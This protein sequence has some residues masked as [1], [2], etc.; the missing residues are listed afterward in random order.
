VLLQASLA[1]LCPSDTVATAL[2]VILSSLVLL[3]FSI[4][5]VGRQPP[6]LWALGMVTCLAYGLTIAIAHNMPTLHAV[7][8]GP[9]VSI[10][11]S[12]LVSSG[13]AILTSILVMPTLASDGVRVHSAW[14]ILAAFCRCHKLLHH[15]ALAT[16]SRCSPTSHNVAA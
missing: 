8:A 3:L 4:N 6:V 2:E 14:T 10:L 16:C 11:L 12:T 5:R 15:D 13:A 1:K 7:W 9:V